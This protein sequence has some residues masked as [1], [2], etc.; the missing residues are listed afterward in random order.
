M[1]DLVEVCEASEPSE[2]TMKMVSVKG[3]DILLA[4]IGDKYYATDNRCPHMGGNLS[5]GKLEGTVVTC[6]KHGSQF[7]LSDGHVVRWL[8]GSGLISKIGKTLKS[9]RPIVT[10][11]VEVKDNKIWVNI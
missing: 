2:G 9:P 7:D 6:P 5:H 4:H 3:K 1:S 10:Y 8:K 11:N